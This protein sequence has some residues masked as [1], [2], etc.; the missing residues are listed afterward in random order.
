MS[1]C[2]DNAGALKLTSVLVAEAKST[3]ETSLTEVTHVAAIVAPVPEKYFP[4]AQF[5][6]AEDK[7]YPVPVWKVP[8]AHAVQL[9]E[10]YCPAGHTTA[11]ARPG[12]SAAS[13]AA[14]NSARIFTRV[15]NSALYNTVSR[16]RGARGGSSHTHTCWSLLDQ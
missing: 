4:V 15:G 3:L 13:P 6:H 10:P 7:V 2:V 8:A 14:S 5:T 16:A 9:A 12:R 11:P 1:T